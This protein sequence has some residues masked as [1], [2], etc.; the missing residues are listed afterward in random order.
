MLRFRALTTL[1]QIEGST[2]VD[3]RG[4]SV[5]DDMCARNNEDGTPKIVDK[6]DG[7]TATDSYKLWKEDIA[8]VKSLGVNSHVS[9]T[10]S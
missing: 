1:G 6:T 7:K 9:C 3:G 10:R 2:D 8:L 5:W 4:P